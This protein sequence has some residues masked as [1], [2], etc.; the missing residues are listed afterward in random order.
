V[1][2]ANT[3]DPV[4]QP[5]AEAATTT[6]QPEASAAPDAAEV[7]PHSDPT[8]DPTVAAAANIVPVPVPAHLNQPKTGAHAAPFAREH[9]PAEELARQSSPPSL[10]NEPAAPAAAVRAGLLRRVLAAL[11]P[12]KRPPSAAQDGQELSEP[13]AEEQR[14]TAIALADFVLRAV[15]RPFAFLSPR[16]RQV[17]G[18]A[19]IVTLAIATVTAALAPLMPKNDPLTFVRQKR[20]ELDRPPPPPTPAAAPA[21]GGKA[22]EA[23]KPA[24][25]H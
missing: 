14:G 6:A 20:A 19:A 9:L 8:P 21:H 25:G 22:P 15:N 10:E 3:E 18:L 7:P 4:N 12:K 1:L 11:R 23:K 5:T 13:G 2:R 16:G 24:S 17:V